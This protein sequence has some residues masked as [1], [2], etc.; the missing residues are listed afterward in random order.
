MEQ[1][2]IILILVVLLT[3][4]D[5]LVKIRNLIL[6][7]TKNLVPRKEASAIILSAKL[8]SERQ[9][10]NREIELRNKKKLFTNDDEIDRTQH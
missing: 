2:Y 9:K 4:V 10:E 3:I 8:Y 7:I 5:L 6:T 1:I